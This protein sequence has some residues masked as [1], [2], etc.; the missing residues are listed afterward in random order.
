MNVLIL[1][2]GLQERAWA[3]WFLTRPEFHLA[4][5]FPRSWAGSMP[6]VRI[7]DDLD[8]ALATAGIELVVVGGPI[9]FRAEALR[10]SAAE[11]LAIICLHPPGEDSEPYY[12]VSLSQR[13]TGAL[14]LPDLPLRL[15]PGV[16]RLRQA[17]ASGQ[18][19]EFRSVR[20][21]SPTHVESEDLVRGAFPRLVDAV[22]FLVGEI[23]TVMASGDPPGEHPEFELVV[24]LRAASSRRAEVRII[25]PGAGETARLAVTGS[26]GSLALEF[27]PSLREPARLIRRTDSDAAGQE[28][29]LE[30]WDPYAAIVDVVEQ[31]LECRSDR[32]APA[33]NSAS[34]TSGAS[35]PADSAAP[36]D[37][38]D[39]TRAMELSEAVARSLRRGRTIDLHYESISEESTFKSIMTSTGCLI[40][41]AIM[42]VLPLA[43][44][45]PPLGFPWT[46]YIAYV[47]P[48]V[49]VV[50]AVLQVL[51]LGIRKESVPPA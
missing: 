24:Q 18:I 44:A 28:I 51:R 16:N 49:L 7:I 25:A 22:R 47:I 3:S 21:E 8:E 1:G 42:L 26:S 15:H 40:L 30:P 33:L 14:V 34:A 36:L 29:P 38:G 46:I 41:L 10:R 13:E 19:G 43:L 11:G 48:P 9:P 45:G 5:A 12:Q 31:A 17:I 23:E 50:F 4:A 27:D 35:R 37:L 20:L 32:L 39:G 2:D 6:E